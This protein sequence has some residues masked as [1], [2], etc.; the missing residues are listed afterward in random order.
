MLHLQAGVNDFLA[1]LSIH[2]S[3]SGQVD[4]PAEGAI[5]SPSGAGEQSSQGTSSNPTSP[6]SDASSSSPSPSG[7]GG[8]G[9][10]AA[11]PGDGGASGGNGGDNN[12]PRRSPHLPTMASSDVLDVVS[13]A[14]NLELVHEIVMNEDFLLKKI[15]HK[16]GRYDGTVVT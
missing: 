16:P 12:D 10:V 5:E 14:Q 7:D 4:V 3:Q 1:G 6:A 8:A 13:L 11:S 9:Q 2:E 15:E